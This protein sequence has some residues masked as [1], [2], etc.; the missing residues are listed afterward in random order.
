MREN[1]IYWDGFLPVEFPDRTEVLDISFLP[2][3]NSV[4]NPEKEVNEALSAPSGIKTIPEL[5]KSGDKVTIAFDDPCVPGK[6][7]GLREGILLS[8]LEELKKAGVWKKDIKLVCATGLHRKWTKRELGWAIGKRIVD[9]FGYRL[10]SH[11]AE[12][13]ENLVFLGETNNGYEI[14]VNKLVADSDLL[15]YTNFLSNIF[16]GGWKSVCVGLSTF[17]SIRYNHGPGQLFGTPLEVRIDPS[18]DPLHSTLNEMGEKIEDVIGKNFFKIETVCNN[19]SEMAAVFAGTMSSTRQSALEAQGTQVALD[20][21]GFDQSDVLIYGLPRWMPYATFS[22]TNPILN[23]LGFGLGYLT[24]TIQL[25]LK[26][27]GTVILVSPCPDVWDEMHHP[28]YIEA[29]NKVLNLTHD[30]Y[31]IRDLF[32]EDFAH[33]PEYIYKYRYCYAY[34]PVHVLFILYNYYI[35]NEY[36]GKVFV[37]GANDPWVVR[38]MGFEPTKTVQEAISRAEELHGKDCSISYMRYQFPGVQTV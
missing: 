20:F 28:S 7:P 26:K 18:S 31:E 17:R 2:T 16:D 13:K 25:L 12:D 15:I 21:S 29:W 33:R 6:T 38:H 27:G 32:E 19:K 22:R 4:E 8:V 24:M 36:I 9:E 30:P 5:V 37:A 10:F 3:M 34:H 14:E 35:T 11:D 1:V 23:V